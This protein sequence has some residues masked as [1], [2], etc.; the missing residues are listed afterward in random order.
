LSRLSIAEIRQHVIAQGLAAEIS[1]STLW[2]LAQS[3]RDLFLHP[4]TEGPHTERFHFSLELEQ[5][6]LA[7]QSH[8]ERT[9][10]PF[11]WTFTR[12][13]LHALLPKIAVKRF[14]PPP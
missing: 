6:L 14:A 1:G 2:Q 12:R 4:S 5:R 3:N 11:K 13:D 10:A 7:F 9:A 8:Y